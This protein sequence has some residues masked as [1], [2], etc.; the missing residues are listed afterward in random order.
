LQGGEDS[1]SEPPHVV[2]YEMGWAAGVLGVSLLWVGGCVGEGIRG[3]KAS[4]ALCF[5]GIA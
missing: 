3:A 4:S 1:H 5:T 2:F